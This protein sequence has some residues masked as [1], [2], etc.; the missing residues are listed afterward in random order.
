M[1]VCVSSR[2]VPHLLVRYFTMSPAG[3]PSSVAA[4]VS[5]ASFTTDT[6]FVC[7]SVVNFKLPRCRIAATAWKICDWWSS[8]MPSSCI[9]VLR[10]TKEAPSVIFMAVRAGSARRS[11]SLRRP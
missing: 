11:K 6:V 10:R 7:G 9:A 2:E 4:I 1:C 5:G 3:T 8:V